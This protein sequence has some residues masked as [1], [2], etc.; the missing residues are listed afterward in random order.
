MLPIPTGL[1]T[2]PGSLMY[3]G[4]HSLSHCLLR[5]HGRNAQH[6]MQPSLFGSNCPS[7]VAL[8]ETRIALA[9]SE[10]LNDVRGKICFGMVPAR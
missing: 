8:A 2:A 1:R 3:Q 4:Y 7:D 9:E 6:S 10:R 5:G